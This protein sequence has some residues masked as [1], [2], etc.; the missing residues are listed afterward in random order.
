M[1]NG[2]YPNATIYFTVI[3]SIKKINSSPFPNPIQSI[4]ISVLI[5]KS[6]EEKKF[7]RL[8]N[9]VVAHSNSVDTNEE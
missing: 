6:Q 9:C 3:P 5:S 4:S 7:Q 1:I 8:Q 2:L